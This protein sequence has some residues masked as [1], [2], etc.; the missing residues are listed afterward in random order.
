M[1]DA[2]TLLELGDESQDAAT[3]AEAR[4]ALAALEPRVRA[5][6]VERLFPEEVDEAGAV[7]EINTGAGGTD[8]CDW[9]QMLM[10]AYLRWADQMGFKA[11]VMDLSPNDEGG[12]KSCA[13]EIEGAYAYG[14]LQAE[15]GVHRLVRISP[16]DANARRQTAFASV[17]AWPDIDDDIEVV[18]DEKDLEISTMRSGGAG[19]QHVNMTDSAVRIVHR[20]SGI[21]V[22]CQNER[23]Q[24]KNKAT[25]MKMLR[26]KLFQ[27]ELDKRQVAID[28]TNAAK[29]K[30]EWGSQIRSYVIH[31]YRQVK[32]RRTGM[33]SSNTDGF[34]DGGILP[35]MEAWLVARAGGTLKVVAGGA[36][37]ED[38]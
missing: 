13:I 22:K 12:I 25:A 7:V 17:H 15:I 11:K 32:D 9:A 21:V 16:Y 26:A 36:T 4:A 8:A 18:I 3:L 20:P 5:M 27:L 35:F 19:G 6:E 10:R 1:E 24:H 2:E 33:E 30:T 34:L 23:S 37:E 31:P 28:A 38:A 29:K 14:Y